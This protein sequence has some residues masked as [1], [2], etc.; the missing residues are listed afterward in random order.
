V[1]VLAGRYGVA[2]QL[3]TG[4][5]RSRDERERLVTAL[6]A[7]L[8]YY[9]ALLRA[10]EEAWDHLHGR[11]IQ[12]RWIE[13]LKLGF[14]PDSWDGI[15]QHLRS[16]GV[17]IRDAVAAGLIKPRQ[18][19]G[20]YDYFR[21][22]IMIPIRDLNGNLVGFGG[23]I[24]GEGEPKYLNSPESAVFRKKNILFGLDTA[25]EAI[26]REGS[27]ILVEGYFDQMSLRIR[28]L[29][30]TV[31][32]LG[33][34]LGS[35]QIRLVKRFSD[36]VITVF[37][38]DDAGIRA[39]KRS[40]PLFLSQ[41][42]EPRCVILKECKDPDE[43]VNKLGVDAFRR[44]LD[45]AP[46][47]VDFLLESLQAQYDLNTLRGRDLA[48][49]E[50][51]PVVKEIA[52]S[53]ERDYLIEKFASRLKIREERLRRM[54]ASG[55]PTRRSDPASQSGRNRAI[56]DFPLD[57]KNVV[58]GMLLK[59]GFIDRVLESGL[60]KHLQDPMLQGLAREIINFRERTGNF[61]PFSFS[62]YLEE[63][64]SAS[65]VAGWISPRPEMDDL[66]PEVGGD[67]A[68]DDSL[69][70]LRMR[71]LEQHKV[72]IQQRMNQN[73]PEDEYNTLAKELWAVGQLLRK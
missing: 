13:D 41:G 39:V 1:Q 12:S 66:R 42:I 14:A 23:R 32:P 28:G 40:I 63:Q 71:V 7:A 29:E 2:L 25:R 31:A 46:K 21:S 50:C 69:D 9:V 47:M 73:P 59:E 48:L 36:S 5:P 49:Q 64:E 51:L 56:F 3:E 53:K 43:A 65:V 55:G 38:G 24:F 15:Q 18:N 6:D 8:S 45:S 57:E 19:G 67:Q 44:L 11:G 20:H 27:V 52:D 61:D 58:R 54:V 17:D 37:D 60:L 22:R 30:N 68:I 26:R 4:L 16:A 10:N 34:S 35:E 72:E 70:R 33:T 62:N